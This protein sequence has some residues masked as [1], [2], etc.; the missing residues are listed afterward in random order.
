MTTDYFKII[1]LQ[2]LID[3]ISPSRDKETIIESYL[4]SLKDKVKLMKEAQE[5]KEKE[6]LDYFEEYLFKLTRKLI[7]INPEIYEAVISKRLELKER[8]NKLKEMYEHRDKLREKK[9]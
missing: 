9:Q 1:E 3:I 5:F 6:M 7:G 8:R 2:K 4:G